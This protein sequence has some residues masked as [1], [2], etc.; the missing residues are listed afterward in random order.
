MSSL[1][2]GGYGTVG[3]GVGVLVVAAAILILL[4]LRETRR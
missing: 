3:A 2:D 1:F 4:I